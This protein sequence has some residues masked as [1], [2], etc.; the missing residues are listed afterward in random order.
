MLRERFWLGWGPPCTPASPRCGGSAPVPWGLTK[1]P[2]AP[3]AC[4]PISLPIAGARAG[5]ARVRSPRAS[6]GVAAHTWRSPLRPQVEACLFVSPKSHM[7]A[8][9]LPGYALGGCATSSEPGPTP[10]AHSGRGRVRGPAVV[11]RRSR[12]PAVGQGRSGFWRLLSGPGPSCGLSRRAQQGAGS[13]AGHPDRVCCT[14]HL[15]TT[16]SYICKALCHAP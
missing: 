2:S 12:C 9:W 14:A 11:G 8:H 1:T 3:Q 7:A 6:V 16:L 13:G 4:R 10:R 5:P 15:V